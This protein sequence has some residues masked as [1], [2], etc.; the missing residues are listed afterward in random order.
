MKQDEHPMNAQ[1]WA[2][3]AAT[4]LIIIIFVIIALLVS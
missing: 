4:I 2:F 3:F 1:S